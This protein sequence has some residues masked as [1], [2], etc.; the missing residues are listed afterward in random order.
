MIG[1]FF[2]HNKVVIVVDQE[3]EPMGIVTKID[4]IDYV[5]EHM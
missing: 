4:F 5:S 3:D 1:E 2:K